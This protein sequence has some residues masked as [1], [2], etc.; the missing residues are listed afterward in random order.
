M[1]NLMAGALE[2]TS[3]H[4]LTTAWKRS[5]AVMCV[6]ASNPDALK[7]L[8]PLCT[9]FTTE[10]IECSSNCWLTLIARGQKI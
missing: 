5:R 3:H 4:R 10:N 7:P 8:Q 6:P 9:S 1:C 2:R